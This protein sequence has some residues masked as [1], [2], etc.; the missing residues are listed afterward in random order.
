MLFDPDLNFNGNTSFTYT[1]TSGG[2][3][4]TATVNITVDPVNDAPTV[5]TPIADQSSDDSDSVNLDVSGSFDDVE[6]RL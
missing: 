5:T 4:E 1:V 2:V 6:D 3:T